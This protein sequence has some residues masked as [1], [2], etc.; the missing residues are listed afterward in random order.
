MSMSF[1][2]QDVGT[3]VKDLHHKLGMRGHGYSR[4]PRV[5]PTTVGS[6]VGLSGTRVAS[7]E[8]GTKELSVSEAAGLADWFKVHPLTLI[9]G[10][11]DEACKIADEFEQLRAESRPLALRLCQALVRTLAE[12]EGPAQ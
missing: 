10:L 3:R 11:P 6:V 8:R 4:K 1:S 12:A 7:V 9:A 5:Q 2:K